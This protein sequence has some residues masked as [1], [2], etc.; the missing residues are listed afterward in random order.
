MATFSGFLNAVIPLIIIIVFAAI[1]LNSFGE[2]LKRFFYWIAG[3]LGYGKEKI[4]DAVVEG[5]G[6]EIIYR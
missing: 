3:L 4:H 1:V 5:G 6:Y 2:P